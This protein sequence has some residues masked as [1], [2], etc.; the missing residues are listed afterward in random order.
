WQKYNFYPR[1]PR[2]GRPHLVGVHTRALHISIHVPRVGDDLVVYN[3]EIT[4]CQFL[5]TSPAWGTT[6]IGAPG[7]NRTCKFL[8][9]SP[10][11]GT[12]LPPTTGTGPHRHFY[13]RPPR[14]GRPERRD[15]LAAC[16]FH[17]FY[18]RPP[19]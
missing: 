3:C 6:R 5:S 2:G 10:A 16:G 14:G 12:T 15:H 9:T 1:P 4:L 18:P 17:H 8:S 7:R 11:W 13:P 19:R